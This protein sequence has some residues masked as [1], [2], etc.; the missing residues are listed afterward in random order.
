[1]LKNILYAILLGVGMAACLADRDNTDEAATNTGTAPEGGPMTETTEFETSPTATDP[2]TFIIGKGRVGSIRIGMP[3]EEMRNQIPTGQQLKDTT[4]ELE[5]QQYT[6]YVLSSAGNA[7]GL[8]VEQA[9]EP[10]CRVWRISIR[11]DNYKTAQGI[12]L[13]SKYSEVVQHHPIAYTNLGEAGFVAVSE[14]SGMSF[15]LD[16]SQLDRNRLH[17]LKPDQV[18]ANT[19][20]QGILIY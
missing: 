1:M 10:D 7:G 12:G 13:G 15:I 11:D 16:T 8:L 20:V 4:L 14:A 19:L 6:A 3:I 9:C 17:Q 2:K 18:P 5:G